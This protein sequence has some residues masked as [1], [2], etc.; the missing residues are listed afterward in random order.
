MLK[1]TWLFMLFIILII[2]LLQIISSVPL[3]NSKSTWK[4]IYNICKKLFWFKYK[5]VF[6]YLKQ[7]LHNDFEFSPGYRTPELTRQQAYIHVLPL[8]GLVFWEQT[9]C[10]RTEIELGNLNM[11]LERRPQPITHLPTPCCFYFSDFLH[12]CWNKSAKAEWKCHI[13]N[14]PESPKSIQLWNLKYLG[15]WGSVCVCMWERYS[16]ICL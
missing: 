15:L 5:V 8:L 7:K 9:N 2:G 10:A 11:L 14:S 13:L 12:A 4:C 6:F 16:F 1:I 3:T